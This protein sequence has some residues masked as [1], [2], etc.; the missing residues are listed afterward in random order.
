MPLSTFWQFF[1]YVWLATEIFIAIRTRTRRGGNVRDRGTMLLLWVVIFTCVTAATWISESNGFNLPVG[2]SAPGTA[3]AIRLAALIVM[4]V[5]LALRW[6]A[7]L[8]LGKSFSAN[9][10]IHATQRVHKTG[11]YRWM[12][13]P[14]YTGLMLCFLAVGLHTRNWIAFLI[15]TVPTTAALLYRIHVEETVLREHFGLEY[16]EYSHRTKR[17]IPGIY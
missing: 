15:V 12:R 2:F 14:S 3:H 7:V 11:L 13:H 10:A 8:S 16:I 4:V 17:L 6:A 5:A 1:F 9:V